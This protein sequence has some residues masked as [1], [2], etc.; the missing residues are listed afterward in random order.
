[1]IEPVG[2][3]ELG[4]LPVPV[5]ERGG[6]SGVVTLD[7]LESPHPARFAIRPLPYGERWNSRLARLF[8]THSVNAARS[9]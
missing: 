2:G 1:M 5:G 9:S 7:R 6:V 8:S 3:R 4:L